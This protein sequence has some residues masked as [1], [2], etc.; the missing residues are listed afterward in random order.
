MKNKIQ[1]IVTFFIA[2]TIS[3]SIFATDYYTKQWTVATIV[4]PFS[5]NSQLRDY[6]EPQ[7]RLIDDPYVFNQSF[8]LMGL[9]YQFFQNLIFFAGPGWVFTK[10]TMGQTSDEYRLWQQLSWQ[11]INNPSITLDSRTRLE[12]KEKTDESSVRV[13]LRQRLWARIPIKNTNNYYYSLFDEVFFNSNPPSWGNNTV[14]YQNRAFIGIAKMVSKHTLID[15]GYLN[16]YVWGQGTQM[17]NVI[18]L[19]TTVTFGRI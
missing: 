7:L 9:G 12:E 14:F 4:G 15:F 18:Y 1:Y 13:D 6:V 17:S 10:N 2:F 11:I 16:Q 3:Q 19:S 5:N 8:I